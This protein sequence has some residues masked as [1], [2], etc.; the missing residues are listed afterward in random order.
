VEV[1]ENR[2]EKK[3]EGRPSKKKKSHV[4]GDRLGEKCGSPSGKG[5]NKWPYR[6]G[7]EP[8]RFCRIR[9]KEARTHH[10]AKRGRTKKGK[11]SVPA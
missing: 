5:E 3:G 10:S 8:E 9:K 6:G 1:P 4:Q 7:E 11:V 2:Q